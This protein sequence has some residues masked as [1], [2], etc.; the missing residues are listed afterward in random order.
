MSNECRWQS[1]DEI[2]AAVMRNPVL[3]SERR[4]D[5]C[6]ESART[7]SARCFRQLDDLVEDLLRDVTDPEGDACDHQRQMPNQ[8]EEGDGAEQKLSG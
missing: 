2:S 4:Q 1:A 3:D 8:T 5:P 6:R 7:G